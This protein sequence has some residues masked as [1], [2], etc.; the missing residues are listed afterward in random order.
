MTKNKNDF[1]QLQIFSQNLG[2]AFQIKDDLLDGLDGSQDHKSYLKILGRDQTLEKLS[3]HS[4]N[5]E[6]ALK[7][8]SIEASLLH[9]IIQFNLNREK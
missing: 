8:L 9:K 6:E 3:Q 2:L 1:T 5:A 7:K 4:Q